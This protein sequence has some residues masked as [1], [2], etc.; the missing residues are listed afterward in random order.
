MLKRLITKALNTVGYSIHKIGTDPAHPDFLPEDVAL[1]SKVSP[2]TITGPE[3]IFALRAA[4]NYICAN[5]IAGDI[6]ECGVFKGGSI[7]AVLHELLRLGDTDR[8]VYLFDT[9]EGMTTP[10]EE[11]VDH[12][13]E[14]VLDIW[15]RPGWW[16]GSPM[17]EVK[18][19]VFSV[20]YPAQNLHFVQGDV[21]NTIPRFSPEKI[22][23]LRL[24]TDWYE[25]TK[26]ELIHLYPNV[27]KRGV[28]IIDD[29]GHYLGARKA[30]DEYFAKSV[31]K[32]LLHRIDYTGRCIVKE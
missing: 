15:D 12:T 13:G 7:M 23:L 9:F 11:D 26:H 5:K 10:T 30:V 18:R 28:V 29:Y 16:V 2:F 1:V 3:R 27:V 14:R 19:N 8:Q 32:P 6:V 21:L 20:G 17:E 24:D 31:F 4:V 22:A 25:S